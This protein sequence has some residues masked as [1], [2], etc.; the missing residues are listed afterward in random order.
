V[1][2]LFKGEAYRL[3]GSGIKTIH[4]LNFV[5]PCCKTDEE[6]FESAKFKVCLDKIKN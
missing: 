1:E 4:T 6:D 2:R 5:L 3:T